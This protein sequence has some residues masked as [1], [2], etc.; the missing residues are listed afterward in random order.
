MY[1]KHYLELFLQSCLAPDSWCEDA[2]NVT[3][4]LTGRHFS[5]LPENGFQQ[6]IVDED[7]LLLK[8]RGRDGHRGELCRVPRFLQELCLQRAL[9]GQGSLREFPQCS[10]PN[11][12]RRLEGMG[13]HWL[14]FCTPHHAPN[15]QRGNACS[16]EG[17][18]TILWGQ[19]MFN[20]QSREYTTLG[21]VPASFH[22]R[23]EVGNDQMSSPGHL[24]IQ[25]PVVW[26]ADA[27]S[28]SRSS[29]RGQQPLLTSVWTR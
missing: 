11:R 13:P 20:S 10:L 18:R 17:F 16:L 19:T 8:G 3:V 24:P 5:L 22:I 4:Q 14:R 2:V 6:G 9:P 23:T 1:S 25:T 29:S 26:S 27:P 15:T 12:Q 21:S 7:V 28:P